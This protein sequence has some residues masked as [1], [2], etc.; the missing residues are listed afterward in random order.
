MDKWDMNALSN[1]FLSQVED[2]ERYL[3]EVKFKVKSNKSYEHIYDEHLAKFYVYN[4]LHGRTFLVSCENLLKELKS[5]AINPLR[6]PNDAYDAQR[7]ENYYHRY[8]NNLIEEFTIAERK[9]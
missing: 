3:E 7:F 9:R 6:A 1:R 4:Y 8:I 5:M 2:T